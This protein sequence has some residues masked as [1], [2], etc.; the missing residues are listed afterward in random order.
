[1]I[2]VDDFA[3]QYDSVLAANGLT[4]RVEPGEILGLIGPNGAGKT[5]TLKALSGVVRP[6]RGKLS[7][8]G[9]DVTTDPVAAKRV[10]AYIPDDPPLFPDLTVDQHLAFTAAAFEV[11]GAENQVDR[12]LDEF[13]LTSKRHT[14]ARDLSRGMRQKLTICCAYLHDPSVI[15]FDEPLTGLDPA[16]IRTLKLSVRRRA[17]AGA[18]VIVSS[19]LLAMVEDLCSHV[20]ILEDG[21]QRFCGPLDELRSAFDEEQQAVTLESIFFLATGET[22]DPATVGV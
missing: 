4:F 17:E 14:L 2:A 12:L 8:C 21:R 16:G 20:L 10:L 13:E 6:S 9:I 18:A 1:M 5:T 19:H 3:K 22:A 15:L 11:A 7:L